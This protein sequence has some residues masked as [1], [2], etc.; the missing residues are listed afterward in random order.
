M[1]NGRPVI[2]LIPAR[3]G[4]K[5][6][7]RKNLRVI[8]GRS[9]VEIALQAAID[10]QR[11][12][13]VFLSSDDSDILAVGRKLGVVCIK[14][15]DEFATDHAS[16]IEVVRHFT[17]EIPVD[18]AC[19]DPYILYLQP[20]SPLRTARHIDDALAEME[21]QSEDRLI[22]VVQLEH[23]PYKSFYID[24]NGKLHSLFDEKFSNARRQDL[25][26]TYV[27]NGAIYIYPVSAFV[28]CD[29]FPSNGSLPY[30]MDKA[31]S[32]DIDSEA[33]LKLLEQYMENI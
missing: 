19:K 2:A 18:I 13:R 17:G 21:K 27:P 8:A 14:R 1:T 26:K 15:P 22:S 9:L 11:V 32:I 6:V 7:T 29:G 31:I 12:D 4:S 20:T 5:G 24:E 23:S 10:S 3:G 30:I 25:P 28:E 16:A 33:D